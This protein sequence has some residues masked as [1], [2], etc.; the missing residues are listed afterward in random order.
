VVVVKVA[1]NTS[2]AEF[3]VLAGNH[4]GELGSRTHNNSGVTVQ[5]TIG[6]PALGTLVNVS[7]N[8][9]R[10]IRGLVVLGKLS[11][12]GEL[13]RAHG[14]W[15]TVRVE[16]S[17][18][19]VGGQD[20]G[21]IE[22]LLKGFLKVEHRAIVGNGDLNGESVLIAVDDLRGHRQ[23]PSWLNDRLFSTTRAQ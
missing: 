16:L 9:S 11:L 10:A 20:T 5:G 3:G 18:S 1:L 4:L 17:K 21:G 13:H 8:S 15:R 12:A 7:F 19:F 6:G 22:L 23:A 2:R 14:D